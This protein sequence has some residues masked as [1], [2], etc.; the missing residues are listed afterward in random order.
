MTHSGAG[1]SSTTLS[2]PA[3]NIDV[4]FTIN[5]LNAKTNGKPN[6]KYIDQVTV[7]Y[8]DGSGGTVQE[9]V[10][11]GNSTASASINISGAVQ[12]VTLTLEDGFDGNSGS[13]V[14]FVSMTN[15]S[16]CVPT[17]S[18]ISVSS[19]DAQALFYPNPAREILHVE[20]DKIVEHAKV[21][22]VDIMGR[23][24]YSKE[25][26]KEQSLEISLRDLT[27]TQNVFFAIIKI[28]NESPKVEKIILLK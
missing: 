10:Y 18:T 2:F 6:K 24:I 16:S 26:N 15:V 8:V 7:T 14:M 9:G 23:M 3:G 17:G 13:T 21:E 4:S 1:S 12:S 19:I 22:L 11:S 5:E 27:F 28:D 20:L 25:M